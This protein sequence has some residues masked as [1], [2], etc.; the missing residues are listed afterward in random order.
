MKVVMPVLEQF[1]MSDLIGRKMVLDRWFTYFLRMFSEKMDEVDQKHPINQ[2]YR[3]K[4]D[5][6]DSITKKIK[7]MKVKTNV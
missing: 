7:I 4:Y 3:D 1:T 5:E 6:Y 2:L